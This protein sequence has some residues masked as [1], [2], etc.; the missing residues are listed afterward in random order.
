M[1]LFTNFLGLVIKAGV[2]SKD[3]SGSAVYS[4]ALI[5]VN[6]MLFVSIW[7]N[8]WTT[9]NATFSRSHAQVRARIAPCVVHA[10]Q[11]KPK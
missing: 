4:V 7:W 8:A 1:I 9:A 11:P 2:A 3:S 5:A 6:V 10:V